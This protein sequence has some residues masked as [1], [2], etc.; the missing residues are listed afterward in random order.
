M[1][2]RIGVVD[3]GI[4]FGHPHIGGD[5]HGVSLVG[6]DASDVADRVGH[7]TAVAAAILEMA[8]EAELWAVRVFEKG[9]ATTARLLAAGIDAAVS[10]NCHLV[11]LSVGTSNVAHQPL[12][13]HAVAEAI[14][15]G[16]LVVSAAGADGTS[17]LPGGLAGVVGVVADP[18]CPRERL[19]VTE[20]GG[21]LLVVASPQPRPIDG[22]PAERNLSGVSFAVAN[23]TG[24]LGRALGHGVPLATASDVYRYLGAVG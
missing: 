16:S 20:R 7:G 5:V 12:F 11:N 6:D 13:E 3:T 8:P 23:A 21:H 19:R 22:V 2:V 15:R 14:A 10:N 9:L 1:K 4:A 24:L 18:Q 17:W